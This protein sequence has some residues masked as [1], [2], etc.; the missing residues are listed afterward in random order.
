MDKDSSSSDTSAVDRR[1]GDA[2]LTDFLSPA[3]LEEYSLALRLPPLLTTIRV[4][5]LK[6]A[7][8]TEALSIL[9]T[10]LPSPVHKHT[11]I[12]YQSKSLVPPEYPSAGCHPSSPHRS[13]QP[14]ACSRPHPCLHRLRQGSPSW[15]QCLCG[16]TLLF[17][18]VT[19]MRS[20]VSWPSWMRALLFL[21]AKRFPSGPISILPA[22]GEHALPTTETLLS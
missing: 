20:L 5:H 8:D 17:M 15:C 19:L 16:T 6:V 11:V 7:S 14:G 4:N 13:L 18:S 2:A 3:Q 10:A 1:F 21:L 22:Q 12:F 9:T